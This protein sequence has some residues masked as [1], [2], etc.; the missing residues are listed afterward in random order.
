MRY[1]PC[2]LTLLDWSLGQEVDPTVLW[3]EVTVSSQPYKN[4]LNSNLKTTERL[5]DILAIEQPGTPSALWPPL[6]R[7]WAMTHSR[8]SKVKEVL[9]LKAEYTVQLRWAHM[10]SC[11]EEK[12]H[13]HMQLLHKAI[14]HRCQEINKEMDTLGRFLEKVKTS[15]GHLSQSCHHEWSD[16]SLPRSNLRE[17][18]IDCLCQGPLSSCSM[19]WHLASMSTFYFCGPPCLLLSEEPH[20]KAPNTRP[21][22]KMLEN[23]M[24]F[25][26]WGWEMR[27]DVNF[28]ERPPLSLSAT[29]AFEMSCSKFGNCVHGLPQGKCQLGVRQWVSSDGHMVHFSRQ[30]I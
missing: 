2:S 20:G 27:L 24:G 16:R 10:V 4:E 7:V 29:R 6:S 9:I 5:P 1:M 14:E 21:L 19:V 11:S 28:K 18:D 30:T 26:F 23:Q 3:S 22:R 25:V 12:A 13:Q 8:F 15:T 17:R